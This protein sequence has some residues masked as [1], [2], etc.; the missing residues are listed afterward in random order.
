MLMSGPS[1]SL[2]HDNRCEIKEG[3]KVINRD[4]IITVIGLTTKHADDSITF[5]LYSIRFIMDD[6]FS[7]QK[8]GIVTSI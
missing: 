3:S 7:D 1:V 4:R 5:I 8:F 2:M 6:N